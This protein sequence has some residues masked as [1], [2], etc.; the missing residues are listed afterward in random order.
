MN[1]KN[2]KT[3]I[4]SK[5]CPDC[6]QP[7]SLKR[8]ERKYIFSEIENVLNFERGIFYTI[9][10][11]II[12]PGQN[13]RNYL[14][15]DRSRLV[16][17]VTFVILTSLIYSITISIF[18]IEEQYVKFQ[19]EG[20]K[21][22]TAMTIFQWIQGHY[23][24]SN[25]VMGVFIALWINLFFKKHKYNFFEILVVLCFVIGIAML[26]FSIF[27]MLQGITSLKIS[28]I[29]GIIGVIYSSWAIGQ[30]FGKEKLFNY[31]KALFAY[32][33]GM[34]TFI[35]LVISIGILFDLFLQ[36]SSTLNL[37]E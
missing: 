9:R 5:F 20:G 1:C 17:P 16:K 37:M 32:L 3:E 28:Q 18:Y 21:I 19:H 36:H 15:E 6:G 35:F 23:G 22:S 33:I 24:Y 8:I 27:A 4:H 7:T 13:I 26:I 14:S 30:F 12:N 11:L 34:I 10:E 29:G 31:I 25:I 2:C